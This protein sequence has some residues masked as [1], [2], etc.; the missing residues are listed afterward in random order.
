M[1]AIKEIKTEI[2]LHIK[3]IKKNE[4]RTPGESKSTKTG[5]YH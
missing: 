2:N 1:V 4:Q 5:F 3:M